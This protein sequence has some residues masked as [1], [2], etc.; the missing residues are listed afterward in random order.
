[1]IIIESKELI[2]YLAKNGNNDS[3]SKNSSNFDK[4]IIDNGKDSETRLDNKRAMGSSAE[5]IAL[6][7]P[8]KR[9]RIT[10]TIQNA[11]NGGNRSTILSIEEREE[12]EARGIYTNVAS[13]ATKGIILS[14]NSYTI[15]DKGITY[16]TQRN[17]L[18]KGML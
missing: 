15:T 2:K 4:Q 14:V 8:E 6:V 3:N 17:S 16:P 7:E 1:M 11:N 10:R 12:L 5:R 13:K 18:H 9:S